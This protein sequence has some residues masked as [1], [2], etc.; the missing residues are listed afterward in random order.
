[1][2]SLSF[3][4]KKMFEGKTIQQVIIKIGLILLIISLALITIGW[5]SSGVY[6]LLIFLPGLLILITDAVFVSGLLINEFIIVIPG[7]FT[8]SLFRCP[9]C[10]K[11][12]KFK[13][14][15]YKTGEVTCRNCGALLFKSEN[16]IKLFQNTTLI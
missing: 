8:S 4:E 14:V 7:S 10:N 12:L 9:K 15:P 1:M 13:Y 2:L 3:R 6:F 5:L 11:K 16:G